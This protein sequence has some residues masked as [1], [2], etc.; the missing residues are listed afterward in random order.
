MPTVNILS[1][2]DFLDGAVQ[3]IDQGDAGRFLSSES[4]ILCAGPREM[5]T[6]TD[7]VPVGLVQNAQL[8][9]NRQIQQLFEVG[10]RKPFFI[11]G[12]TLTQ[13]GVS[14]ILFDGPSLMKAMYMNVTTSPT[15]GVPNVDAADSGQSP[16]DPYTGTAIDGSGSLYINLAAEFFNRPTGLAFVFQDMAQGEDMGG[17]YLENCYLQTHSISMS[18][19]QTVLLENVGVRCGGVVPFAREAATP[20]E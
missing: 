7:V 18:G 19:Q 4:S 15:V 5:G 12:R 2:W 11:P 1:D 17:I 20:S 9:Q 8:S 16:S 13:L 14:R 3:P 10:S 6:T